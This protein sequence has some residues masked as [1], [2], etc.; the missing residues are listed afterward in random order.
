VQ[1]GRANS[2]PA[3][4][5]L[6]AAQEAFYRSCRRA[7]FRL[8]EPGAAA[9]AGAGPGGQSP[10]QWLEE[11]RAQNRRLAQDPGLEAIRAE[12][13][14]RSHLLAR[15]GGPGRSSEPDRL[16]GSS[17]SIPAENGRPIYWH[18]GPGFAPSR[19]RLSSLR[20]NPSVRLFNAVGLLGVLLALGATLHLS[21]AISAD[22]CRVLAL[23]MAVAW[24]VAQ[25]GSDLAG[26]VLAYAELDPA[27][28]P[29]GR[30]AL[31]TAIALAGLAALGFVGWL[32]RRGYTALRPAHSQEE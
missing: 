14:R 15:P 21:R 25:L 6:W 29:L 26:P 17:V 20:E 16:T 30:Q 27:W 10:A 8:R 12:A 3:N 28:A 24:V 11:L 22:G 13:E 18:S 5:Q 1:R 19:L 7:E 31:T 4:D 23:L 32:L 2:E 9:T